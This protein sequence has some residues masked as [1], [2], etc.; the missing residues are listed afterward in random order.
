MNYCSPTVPDDVINYNDFPVLFLLLLT[1]SI[2]DI[3]DS[4]E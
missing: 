1:E 2:M 3:T 4:K